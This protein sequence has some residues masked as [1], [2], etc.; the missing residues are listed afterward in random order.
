MFCS[1][2]V[3]YSI[4][5]ASKSCLTRTRVEDGN[6]CPRANLG[7]WWEGTLITEMSSIAVLCLIWTYKLWCATWHNGRHGHQKGTLLVLIIQD[8]NFLGTCIWSNNVMTAPLKSYLGTIKMYTKTL[9]GLRYSRADN[10][11]SIF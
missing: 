8:L 9:Y 3:Q 5:V 11:T 2:R 7:H 6:T 1:A 4:K 10:I